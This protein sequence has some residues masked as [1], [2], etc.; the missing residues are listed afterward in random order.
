MITRMSD[1]YH[2]EI[3][4]KKFEKEWI[5]RSFPIILIVNIIIITILRFVLDDY[6]MTCFCKITAWII[7]TGFVLVAFLILFRDLFR[8][9]IQLEGG[10]QIRKEENDAHLHHFN[11]LDPERDRKR[12]GESCP[13]RSRDGG[14]EVPLHVRDVPC[15]IVSPRVVRIQLN[16]GL[17]KL[18]RLAEVFVSIGLI[19]EK[20]GDQ[21]LGLGDIVQSK[22]GLSDETDDPDPVRRALKPGP[23]LPEELSMK[24]GMPLPRILSELSKLE[25][26]GV[27]IRDPGG[28]FSLK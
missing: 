12:Q 10:V 25:L 8:R 16:R 20:L 2:S 27:V 18:R 13:T 4:V 14:I 1:R 11:Q 9:Y 17:E 5:N 26:E 28:Q 23:Q 7:L 21:G 3:I 24:T 15:S 6:P 19:L 22:T